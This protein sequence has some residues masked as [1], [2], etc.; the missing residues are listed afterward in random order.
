MFTNLFFLIILL[1]R[2]QSLSITDPSSILLNV[3]VGN[4]FS[5]IKKI[6]SP[7]KH[8]SYQ[9]VISKSS[10][11]DLPKQNKKKSSRKLQGG[12]PSQKKSPLTSNV[13]RNEKNMIFNTFMKG[14]YL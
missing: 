3:K 8:E 4:S 5:L 12:S 6:R 2:D 9:N 7:K 1:Y 11:I 14:K 13:V 10:N